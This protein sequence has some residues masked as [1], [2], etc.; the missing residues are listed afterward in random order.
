MRHTLS[1][2]SGLADAIQR[3]QENRSSV[4]G[5]VDIWVNATGLGSRTLVHDEGVFPT[6]GQT[7]LVKGE[8]RRAITWVRQ[9]GLISYV[10]PRP[11]SRGTILGGCNQPGNW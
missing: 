2:D 5:K 6:R 4:L 11:G 1:R 7:I 8:A 9:K 3:V 10:I